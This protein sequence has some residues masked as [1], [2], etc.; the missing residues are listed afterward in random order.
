MK[1]LKPFVF[2]LFLTVVAVLTNRALPVSAAV[3][4]DADKQRVLEKTAAIKIPFIENRGQADS[5]VEFYARIFTGT[6]FVDRKGALTYRLPKV[7]G[8]AVIRE[9]FGTGKPEIRG[10][11]PSGIKVSSFTGKDKRRWCKNL[12]AYNK[13]SLGKVYHH[14]DLDLVAY[15]R[16]VEKRFT[17]NPGG[18][19]EDIR[20][21]VAGAK[22]L[23]ITETGELEI[24]TGRG[25]IRM[26]APVAWQDAGGEKVMVAAEYV[27][28][29]APD[30]NI[31][32]ASLHHSK[33]AYGFRV[34]N[35]DQAKPLI[36][37]PLLAATFLGGGEEERA[38]ALALDAT[39]VYVTGHTDSLDFPTTSGAYDE[40]MDNTTEQNIFVSRFDRNLTQ[41][42]ASTYLGGNGDEAPTSM[43]VDASSVYLLGYTYSF[44]FPVTSGA[45]DETHNSGGSDLF[46]AK[47]DKSLTTLQAA[48]FLG[49]TS[50]DD[51]E[52]IATDGSSIFVCGYTASSDFPTRI[53]AYIESDNS[54]MH[55]AGRMAAAGIMAFISKLDKSLTTL[56]AG[57]FLGGSDTDRA[58]A[59]AVDA[60]SVYVAGDTA[61]SDFPVV[62]G[63]FDTTPDNKTN[64]FVSKLDKGLTDLEAG[65]F[66][67]GNEDE[68]AYAMALDANSVYVTG[69]TGSTDF[70]MTTGSYDTSYKGGSEG[71]DVFIARLNKPLTDLEAGTFL[72]GSLDETGFSIHADGNCVYLTGS[73][74]SSNFPISSGAYA[75]SLNGSSSDAFIAILDSGLVALSAGT[76]IGG[77]DYDAGLS[78]MADGSDIF[79]AGYTYSSD[80]PATDGAYDETAG[81]G[82]NGDAF[83]LKIDMTPEEVCDGVDND[84]DGEI[85]EVCGSVSPQLLKIE[86]NETTAEITI[87]NPGTEPMAW[88][89]TTETDW[90]SLPVDNGTVTATPYGMT[91]VCDRT[92]L[93]IGE[94]YVGSVTVI[95]GE[96]VY[97]VSVIM[98]VV[99][100]K[101]EVV[102]TSPITASRF[103]LGEEISF[104]ATVTDVHDNST[105]ITMVWASDRDGVIGSGLSLARNNLTAG[106]HTITVTATDSGGLSGTDN[107]QIVVG[108]CLIGAAFGSR[109][110]RLSLFRRFRD[111]QLAKTAPGR[112]VVA[113][114]YK[115]GPGIIRLM[116]RNGLVKKGI[117]AVAELSI[118]VVKMFL[119]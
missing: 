85:D 78:L 79:V 23:S 115:A 108:G 112:A 22:K 59:V 10:L 71:G 91:V 20:V 9:Y 41:L 118:P 18:T 24:D 74:K 49:G 53:G 97:E 32:L 100:T 102:I 45:Y 86:D 31:S 57:T 73:T 8:G 42:S 37:D 39:S 72:G 54:S 12:P 106:E 107:V 56:E 95:A 34:G 81:G 77:T 1:N 28:S 3:P 46:L 16:N 35:Y 84:C 58:Y 82:S 17:V 50:A 109:D 6:L 92:G 2:C 75:E 26:T 52:A 47:F 11:D 113:A 66:L 83:V 101:P 61:S 63:A 98:D 5:R 105:V 103:T 119:K 44:D 88:S 33:L 30:K 93:D 27:L 76:Y 116:E 68:R 104:T 48:T 117:K 99:N 60:S 96:Q 111:E 29:K 62:S 40:S 4:D 110:A 13:L 14:I 69:Y 80:F 90:L 65:T 64:V 36:I 67:G 21:D 15:G 55:M 25:K 7:N 70:P 19:A 94:D 87:T 43:V 51:G 89:A 114:Y 38:C